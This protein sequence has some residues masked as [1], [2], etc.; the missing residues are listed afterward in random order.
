MYSL[1]FLQ[2]SSP[3]H[4]QA[5]DDVINHRDARRRAR[6]RV[7]G[8][9]V[10]RMMDVPEVILESD[11]ALCGSGTILPAHESLHFQTNLFC[12]LQ[13]SVLYC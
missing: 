1:H 7:R 6:V 13:I 3:S 10:G 9:E 12:L 4:L 5:S 2:R 11:L 8:R